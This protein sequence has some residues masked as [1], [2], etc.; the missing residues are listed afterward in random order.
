MNTDGKNERERE[1]EMNG[2]TFVPWCVYMWN[3]LC[4]E[5]AVDQ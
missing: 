3:P 1:R 4:L 2:F 5:E